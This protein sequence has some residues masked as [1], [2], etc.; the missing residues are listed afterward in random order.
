MI[1]SHLSLHKTM[2]EF[3]YQYGIEDGDLFKIRVKTGY[4]ILDNGD[5]VSLDNDG[6]PTH[7]LYTGYVCDEH[8]AIASDRKSTSVRR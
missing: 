5:I 4:V 8:R 6:N 2:R 1:D 3:F 7:E